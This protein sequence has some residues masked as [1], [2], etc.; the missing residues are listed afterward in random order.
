VDVTEARLW[1]GV[2]AAPAAWLVA[3]GVG[4]VM[5]ARMCEPSIGIASSPEATHARAVNTIVCVA[6]LIIALVGLIAA[7]GNAREVR[8]V[9]NGRAT[10]LSLGGAFTS[11]LFTLGIVLFSLPAFVVNVCNQAR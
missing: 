3:E 1:T 11:A 7:I 10:F 2:L 4:Y 5:A 8:S 6:C 9:G